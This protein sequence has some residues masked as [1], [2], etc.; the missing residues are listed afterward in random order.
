[1]GRYE[2][3]LEY[4]DR[5]IAMD[6]KNADAHV[7]RGMALLA[8]GRHAEALTALDRAAGIDPECLVTHR[9]RAGSPMGR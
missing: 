2:R 1:M 5:V 7:H 9:G 6:A 4:A 3:D 8:L